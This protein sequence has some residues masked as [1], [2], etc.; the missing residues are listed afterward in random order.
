M[1]VAMLAAAVA[2]VTG[3]GPVC[4]SSAVCAVDGIS[5]NDTVCDGS[6]F[7]SCDSSDR[8]AV[9]MCSTRSQEA[10]CTPSGWAFQPAGQNPLDGGVD[11]R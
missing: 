1:R 2:L 11:A 4:N 10:V 9:I 5:P 7:K 3:C 8:G 6:S